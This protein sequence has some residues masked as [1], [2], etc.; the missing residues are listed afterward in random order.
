MV[1]GFVPLV[2][3]IA[4]VGDDSTSTDAGKD[5]SVPVDGSPG[6]GAPGDSSSPDVDAG[7]CPGKS[8]CQPDGGGS[9]TCADLTSDANNCGACGHYCPSKQCANSDCVRRVF[10]TANGSDGEAGGVTGS[11]GVDSTCQQ[12]A[13]AA[14]LDGTYMAWLSSDTTSPAVR[15]TKSKAPYVRTDGTKV[16]NDWTS[17]TSGTLLS[18]I[19]RDEKAAVVATTTMIWTDTAIDGTE[20]AQTVGGANCKNWVS[21]IG[22]DLG[23][24]GHVTATDG[25]WTNGNQQIVCTATGNFYCFEQ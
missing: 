15:F 21:T 9:V 2:T 20:I 25:T 6:D 3:C 14:G 8:V 17:L 16:A 10:V 18:P 12:T 22:G 19:N 4:C 11:G 1:A 13:L 5:A 24:Y 7:P 23:V